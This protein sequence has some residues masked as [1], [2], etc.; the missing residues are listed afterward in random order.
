M[1]PIRLVTGFLGSGKTTLLKNLIRQNQS[2]RLAFLVNEFSPTDIDGSLIAN[3]T[4]D[5]LSIPGGSIFCR[6]LADPRLYP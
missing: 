4:P 6:C 3:L 5:Y 2:R 1:I